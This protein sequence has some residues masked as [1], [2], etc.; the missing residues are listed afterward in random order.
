MRTTL[1]TVIVAASLAALALVGACGSKSTGTATPAPVPVKLTTQA[2]ARS[3]C[4]ALVPVYKSEWALDVK[5][6]RARAIVTTSNA[7]SMAA[8]FNDSFLPVSE[9]AQARLRAIDPPPLFRVAQRRLERCFALQS[10]FLYFVQDELRRA[11][12]T[13]TVDPVVF[14]AE[15]DRYIARIKAACRSWEVTLRTALKRSGVK[16]TP[17]PLRRMILA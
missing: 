4:E 15:M 16:E 1:R 10:D 2:Q 7:F 3:Y 12:F 17:R 11:N 6:R 8:R 9:Q 5:T 13:G 14:K